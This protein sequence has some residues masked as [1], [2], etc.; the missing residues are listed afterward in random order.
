MAIDLIG[1][2]RRGKAYD[3]HTVSSTYLGVDEFG[4]DRYDTHRSEMGELVYRLK[5]NGDRSAAEKIVALLDAI[6]GIETFDF[7]V[8]IP[9]T[10]K[11]RPFRPVE[12]ITELLGRRRGV[13]ILTGLLDNCGDAELKDIADPVAR[14]E[15]LRAAMT[16]AGDAD[17]RGSKILLVD[18]LYRSGATLAAATEILY[19]RAGAGTVCVLTMTKTRSN[20]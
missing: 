4:H 8:P 14:E 11:D 19:G 1:N 16:L 17:I 7:L 6:R 5:Y 15:R 12:L 3:L 20:R 10:R 18:D 13:R 9:P 2:W